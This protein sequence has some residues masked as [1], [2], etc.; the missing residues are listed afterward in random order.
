MG[1]D[2]MDADPADLQKHSFFGGF[3]AEQI[4][5]IIPLMETAIFESGAVI[6]KE[7]QQNDRIYF[8]LEGR[9]GVSKN[10]VPLRVFAEGEFFGE[11]EVIDI[12]PA[13]ATITALTRVRLMSLSN[14]NLHELSK[15]DL[16][17]FALLI[18]NV[19]RDLSRR[20]RAM[21]SRYTESRE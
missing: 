15:K 9:V 13:E 7:G 3:L 18:M 11:M 6:I 20:L 4:Q 19:A 14:G 12:M 2:G 5:A 10:E 8:M 21:N 17:A 16:K 1:D